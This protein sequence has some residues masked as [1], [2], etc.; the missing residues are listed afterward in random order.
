MSTKPTRLNLFKQIDFQHS[1][2][3]YYN[4]MYAFLPF[5]FCHTVILLYVFV[6]VLL[7]LFS[8]S[9]HNRNVQIQYTNT[10]QVLHAKKKEV[11]KNAS[12]TTALLFRGEKQ[13]YIPAANT[14][15]DTTKIQKE[16]DENLH[17]FFFRSF[18][19]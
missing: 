7:S 1:N 6:V 19:F 15:V 17:N 5:V 2:R 11:K 3:K 13:K 4:K 16:S 14:K 9:I 12:C 18:Y 8:S 10:L